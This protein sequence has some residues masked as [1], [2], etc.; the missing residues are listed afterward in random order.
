MLQISGSP[1]WLVLGT[2]PFATMGCA[3]GAAGDRADAALVGPDMAVPVDASVKVPDAPST[4]ADTAAGCAIS[5]GFTP[6]LD[7]VD[8]LVEYPAAQRIVPG[9]TLSSTD[10]VAI[11]WSSTNLF[12]TATSGAFVAPYEPMHVYVQAGTG[13]GAP[14]ASTGKEYSGL[15][16]DLPFVPSQLI[17]IRRISDAGSGAYNG[18]FVPSD[19]WTARTA[20]LDAIASSDQRTLSVV[21]PW[22][23]LGGCPS[24]LR[25]ALHVV[26]AQVNNEWKDL[27]PTT[28][29]PWLGSS[30]GFYEIDLTAPPPVSGWSLR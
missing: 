14:T 26:N 8:D 17:A 10:V 13:L 28:H 20:A 29:A 25:L 9:A 1:R 6:V 30:S 16:P 3:R 15:V 18:V 2:L 12:I 23:L 5:A 19:G 7:G 22:A 11:G 24:T 27:V 4:P 21:V